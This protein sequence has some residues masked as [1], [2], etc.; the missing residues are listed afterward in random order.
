[1]SAIRLDRRQRR[2]ADVVPVVAADWFEASL[3]GLLARHGDLATRAARRFNL[4]PLT[5]K[6]GPVL[7]G[8]ALRRGQLVPV[9]SSDG[10]VVEVSDDG[11]SDWVHHIRNVQSLT[12]SGDLRYT[13]GSL[14]TL[15]TWQL[16]LRAITDGTPVHEPGSVTFTD[17]H[18]AP[19]D[20]R[21]AFAPDDDPTDI[22]HFVREAGFLHL[23]GWLDPAD[24][25]TIAADMDRAAAS[26]RPDDGRSWWATLDSGD[27]VCVRMRYF[28]EHSEAT[29]TLLGSETWDR[30]RLAI[31]GDEELLRAPVDGNIIEGL[32]KPVGVA[33]GISD[34]PWHRDCAFG[35]HPYKCSGVV[36]GVSVTGGDRQTGLLRVVAGSHRAATLDDPRWHGND[37]P[38]VPLATDVGD[39][40][41]HVHCTCHEALP[42]RSIGRKVMYTG[43]GLPD[44]GDAPLVSAAERRDLRNEVHKVVSQPPNALR[45]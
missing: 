13:G 36:V 15:L 14:G 18:G 19:L 34:V 17:R 3:P 11:F 40:T 31:A 9:A 44:N 45:A 39:V 38:V 28:V 7:A 24:M 37:L 32:F 5:I 35:G 43:F 12:V 29:A 23:R 26:Y 42:P 8:L 10:L 33:K 6:V 20:L 22:A 41:V 1:M 4:P 16:V 27:E 2:F 21:R 30:L 25:A